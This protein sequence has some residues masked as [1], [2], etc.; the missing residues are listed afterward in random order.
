MTKFVLLDTNIWINLANEPKHFS[1]LSSL[2]RI[3]S[4]S[5]CQL[6]I[7]E[8]VKT[9]FQRNDTQTLESF[10]SKYQKN[11]G[12][13][14]RTFKNIFLNQDSAINELNQLKQ[15]A[16]ATLGG[17]G[18]SLPTN[19]DI[20]NNLFRDAE[21]AATSHLMNEAANRCLNHL[22][23]ASSER[24]SVG[25]CLLWLSI[26]EYLDKGDVYFCTANTKDFSEKNRL[27]RLNADL[28]S[29]AESKRFAI[30]FFHDLNQLINILLPQ[31]EALPAFIV[32]S[33]PQFVCPVCHS[34][35]YAISY[36]QIVGGMNRM[37]VCSDCKTTWR[38][39][40]EPIPE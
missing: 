7:P 37:G 27:D 18:D 15:K 38:I 4:S 19:R 11:L 2:S 34:N 24:S 39:L 22:P 20:I 32:S 26:L 5:D 29:E 33:L 16:E 3:V 12:E 36:R 31:S 1:Q 21:Q 28:Q 35:N 23:P 25:D 40:F 14:Y 13:S 30:N 9:E 17:L 6:V 10:K 8:S